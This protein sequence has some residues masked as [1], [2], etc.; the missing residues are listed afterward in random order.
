MVMVPQLK[1]PANPPSVGQPDTIGYRTE[2]FFA[3]LVVSLVAAAAATWIRGR[4]V[5][6]LGGWNATLAVG[7]GFVVVIAVAMLLLPGI[8]EVPERFPAVLLWKFRVASLGT[9][10]VLWITLGLVFGGLTQRSLAPARR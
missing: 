4:L 7:A 8:N 3:M 6:R 5:P 9:Q 2:L 10:A 1:Y